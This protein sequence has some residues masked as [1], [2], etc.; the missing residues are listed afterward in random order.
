M[1]EALAKYRMMDKRRSLRNAPR[2]KRAVVLFVYE[3]QYILVAASALIFQRN[4]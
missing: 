4:E 3:V 1:Q 2:E